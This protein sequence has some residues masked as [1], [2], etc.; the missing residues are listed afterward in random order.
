MRTIGSARAA[1]LAAAVAVGLAAAPAARAAELRIAVVQAQAG[2][3]RKFQPLLQYL[4]AKGVSASF[5]AAPD[6]R[7]AAQL[8]ATGGVDAMFGG[9]G[10][11]GTM[12]IKGLASPAVRA[13]S[14]NGADTYHAVVIAPRGV[15]R[16]GGGAGYFAGKRVI[17][18]ALASA[19]EFYF[20][21]LGPSQAGALLKAAS[22]GAALDALSRGQADVA[23]V[24]NHVWEKEKEKHPGLELVGADDGENPDGS[25]VVS[26]RLAPAA[27]AQVTTALLGLGADASPAAAAAR[28]ALGIRGY[29]PAVEKDFTQTLRLLRRAGVNKDFGFT[30]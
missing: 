8:F 6:Y 5:V 22:H 20:H 12:M 18:S 7:A 21:S 30:F 29:V 14:V 23:I 2:D 9:S 17:F 15:A 19:G 27:A 25:L 16:F 1:C 28:D 3:A 10:I 13:A 4:A 26:R 24:K 11:A